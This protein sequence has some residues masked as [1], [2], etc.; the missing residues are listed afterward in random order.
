MKSKKR[1]TYLSRI[2]SEYFNRKCY[3]RRVKL[4]CNLFFPGKWMRKTQAIRCL[5]VELSE[6]GAI[7]RIGKS[8]IPDQ[9]YL[10]IGSFDVVIGSIVVQRGPGVLHLCFLRELRQDFVNRLARMDS[11]FSTLES[12]SPRTISASKNVQP[13]LRPIPSAPN[14]TREGNMAKTPSVRK[15]P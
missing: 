12:L 7:V 2:E 8:Q 14:G 6:G 4:F 3:H 9:L 10:V 11:P 13:M 5:I 1:T 15:S